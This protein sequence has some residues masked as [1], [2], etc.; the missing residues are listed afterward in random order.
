MPA[1]QTKC[2][3]IRCVSQWSTIAVRYKFTGL[4][5]WRPAADGTEGIDT[6]QPW[7]RNTK[8]AQ[9]KRMQANR[10][11]S[12][13]AAGRQ[14]PWLHERDKN[15]T[16]LPPWINCGQTPR[17]YACLLHG[18]TLTYQVSCGRWQERVNMSETMDGPWEGP[19][20]FSILGIKHVPRPFTGLMAQEGRHERMQ[21]VEKGS[22]GPVGRGGQ[23]KRAWGLWD[24][25]CGGV[26]WILC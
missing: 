18:Y 24:I 2:L 12:W 16:A 14:S 9:V 5:T 20:L 23:T 15:R 3:R 22:I 26:Y 10:R 7:H 19:L 4:W 6:D 13:R 11:K 21:M 8:G 25:L 17:T 1:K